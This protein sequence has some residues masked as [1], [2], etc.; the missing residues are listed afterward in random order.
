M[1]GRTLYY[2]NSSVMMEQEWLNNVGDWES[3]SQGGMCAG[4]TNTKEILKNS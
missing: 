2:K 4:M 1:E 3:W